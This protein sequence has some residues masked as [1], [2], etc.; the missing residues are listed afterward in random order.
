MSEGTAAQIVQLY[1]LRMQIEEYFRDLKNHRFGWSLEDV[2]CGSEKRLEVLLLIAT[3][4]MFI[5]L[6]IGRMAEQ[7]G[8]H[9]RYQSNTVSNRRVLSFFVLGSLILQRQDTDWITHETLHG[10]LCIVRQILRH[11]HGS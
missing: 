8:H 2:R 9:R 4:A 3:L 1:S 5:I 11:F 6:L 7:L 10:Q